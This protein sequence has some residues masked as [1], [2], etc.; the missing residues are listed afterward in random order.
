VATLH[1]FTDGQVRRYV[2][3]FTRAYRMWEEKWPDATAETTE[4]AQLL[5]AIQ[6]N[7]RLA[8]LARNPFML[9]V[10][11]LINRAEGRLPRHRVQ[12][13]A[14]FARALCETWAHARRIV[15]RAP[16]KVVAF[17]EEAIPI[18]GGLARAMPRPTRLVLR[19]GSSS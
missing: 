19:P 10:L 5:D 18:L 9:A 4:A 7:P 17:E 13:Y 3:S 16:E 6:Q 1:P 11:A 12:F 2:E 15:A 14:I 8:A